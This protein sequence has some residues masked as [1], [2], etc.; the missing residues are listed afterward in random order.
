LGTGLI[1]HHR[2]VSAV[3]REE[4]VNDS[5]SYMVLRGRWCNI[6]VLNVYVTNEEKD[7]NAKVGEGIFSNWQL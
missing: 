2:I 6:I 1:V 5:V 4:F 3:Q 7:L